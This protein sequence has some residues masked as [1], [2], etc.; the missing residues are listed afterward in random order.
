M[1]AGPDRRPKAVVYRGRRLAVAEVAER[2][3]IDDEWW[4]DQPV[5]R[6][7][8]ELVMADGRKLVVF[9]DLLTGKWFTQRA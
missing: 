2:W 3:R 1:T 8:Y 4:R 6:M 9:E 7:Y 5:S